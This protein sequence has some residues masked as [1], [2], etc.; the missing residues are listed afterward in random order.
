MVIAR[1]WVSYLA[2]LSVHTSPDENALVALAIEFISSIARLSS[3]PETKSR[4]TPI[5]V[6]ELG[7][8]LA[9]G[10]FPMAQACVLYALRT[11]VFRYLTE[12]GQRKLV[13]QLGTLLSS[14]L[15]NCVPVVVCS[16]ESVRVLLSI[17]GEVSPE[18][19]S[20]LG[21]TFMEKLVSNSASIRSQAAAALGVLVEVDPAC[22]AT[23][24]TS[25]IEFLKNQIEQLA[26]LSARFGAMHPIPGNLIT[27]NPD[28]FALPEDAVKRNHDAC[29]REAMYAVYGYSAG[30]ASLL[31]A[32][33]RTT[34]SVPSSV[35]N[36]AFHFAQKLILNAQSTVANAWA[37]E[38]KAGYCILGAICAAMPIQTL[39]TKGDLLELFQ[40]ALGTTAQA[41]MLNKGLMKA[42]KENDVA[43]QLW[44]RS[45]ALQTLEVYIRA[46][47]NHAAFHKPKHELQRIVTLLAPLLEGL[48][49][50][51]TLEDPNQAV[52]GPGGWIAGTLGNLQLRL[53]NIFLLFPDTNAFSKEQSLLIKLC[54]QPFSSS[55]SLLNSPVT[56]ASIGTMTL[57]SILNTGDHHLGPWEIEEEPL[58]EKLNQMTGEKGAPHYTGWECGMPVWGIAGLCDAEGPKIDFEPQP[59]PQ[60][61]S[62]TV[63][64]VQAQ[65]MLFGKLLESAATKNK[66]QFLDSLMSCT[67]SVKSLRNLALQ[68]AL[69]SS[70]C[71]AV[72]FGFRKSRHKAS[73]EVVK[74]MMEL[75]MAMIESCGDQRAVIRGTAEVLAV[76]AQMGDDAFALRLTKQLCL[77]LSSTTSSDRQCFLLL[78]I[79]C[80]F[81]SK[82]GMCLQTVLP[83]VVS[84]LVSF[85][86][87]FSGKVL[88]WT[89]HSLHLIALSAGLPFMPYVRTTLE[90][91]QQLMTKQ[92]DLPSIRP[93]L[94]RL[95]NA[96]VA[97]LGPEL[98]GSKN[99]NMCKCLMR[100]MTSLTAALSTENI[101]GALEVVLYAQQL[102]LFAPQAAPAKKHVSILMDA[103]NLPHPS[104]RH[105]AAITLRHLTER[106]PQTICK[107]GLEKPLF[108][109][110]D[111]ESEA[112][113]SK[114]L[115]L[116]LEALQFAQCPTRCSVWLEVCASIVLTYSREATPRERT[117][118]KEGSL[119]REELEELDVSAIPSSSPTSG[120][121]TPR[122]KT[123]LFACHCLL[124]IFEAVGKDPSHFDLVQAKQ[125]SSSQEYL[126][127]QL[128]AISFSKNL[129]LLVPFRKL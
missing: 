88:L 27:S 16:L 64:L 61:T 78:S 94:G 35:Y 40:P 73:S 19:A 76:A 54:S 29:I 85:A 36:E 99:Y 41:L 24:I 117:L 43:L 50:T 122:L 123:R 75:A 125:S 8:G 74:K 110:L 70:I 55:S 95:T 124:K 92:D 7:Y 22:A 114:A 56:A 121:R 128:Q 11:G 44:W 26:S 23:L 17:L 97:V 104:L 93:F 47:V 116:T 37:I 77:D 109:A 86:K 98:A 65:V 60:Y 82:G 90:L 89:L 12:S 30:L 62:L 49:S 39:K 68:Q 115:I 21:I 38:M 63:A 81:R 87:K 106:D 101:A 31:V 52:G 126:V 45:E 111:E 58:E 100:Q 84:L 91:S 53:L 103:L 96:M 67:Q 79:G 127:C 20:D 59:F 5:P 46:V 18:T 15:G 83:N 66:L 13:D 34:L 6:V 80:L 119:M 113:I 129:T 120:G 33:S 118:H 105:Q 72:L 102:I 48:T 1:S 25:C 4:D 57:R 69:M 107:E 28:A 51:I 108:K 2:A 10:E 112:H 9:T 42:G 3:P 32:A 14:L 71:Y